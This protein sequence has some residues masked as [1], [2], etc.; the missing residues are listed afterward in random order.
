MVDTEV[1]KGTPS[2][3][4]MPARNYEFKMEGKHKIVVPIKGNYVDIDPEFYSEEDGAFDL[5]LDGRTF[6]IL[7]LSKVLFAT[8]KYPNLEPSQLFLPT[9]IAVVDDNVEIFGQVIEMM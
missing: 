5:F 6:N 8:K 2:M 4:L 7:E 1:F 9:L 3:A